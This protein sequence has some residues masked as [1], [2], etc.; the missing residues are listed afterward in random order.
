MKGDD[1]RK[2]GDLGSRSLRE[3]LWL[4][5]RLKMA[6]GKAETQLFYATHSSLAD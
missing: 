5:R 4:M 6:V 2:H 1:R 3:L